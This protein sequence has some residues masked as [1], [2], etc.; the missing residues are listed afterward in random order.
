MNFRCKQL[1]A[2]KNRYFS[3]FSVFSSNMVLELINDFY[4][5]K[6]VLLVSFSSI[7]ASFKSMWRSLII[8]SKLS[9]KNVGSIFCDKRLC[10][11]GILKRMANNG[12]V[13]QIYCLDNTIYDSY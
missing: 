13:K 8:E 6:L 2:A 9:S 12:P 10:D 1:L 11:N 7:E 5:L 4:A 3:K